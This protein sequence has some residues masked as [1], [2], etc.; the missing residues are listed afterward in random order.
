LWEKFQKGRK[1]EKKRELQ[2]VGPAGFLPSWQHA[3]FVPIL[4]QLRHPNIIGEA[5]IIHQEPNS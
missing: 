3:V 5:I 2:G 4:L 1:N